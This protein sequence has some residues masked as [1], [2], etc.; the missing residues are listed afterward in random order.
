MESPDYPLSSLEKERISE[1]IKMVPKGYTSLLDVGARDGY[2]CRRLVNEFREIYLLDLEK[3]KIDEPSIRTVQ[4]DVTHLEFFGDSFDVVL[5]AEVLEHI[6]PELLDVACKEIARVSRH[7]VVIGV[8]Y[9][10]DIRVGRT[11]CGNC[12]WKNPPWGHV[13]WFDGEKLEKLFSPLTL[14]RRKFIGSKKAKTNFIS[15]FLMDLGGNPW[16]TYDQIETCIYCG[17][18]LIAPGKRNIFERA[19]SKASFFLNFLQSQFI[20]STP[21]WLYAVFKKQ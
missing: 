10:Q 17:K 11:T 8:P 18:K 7:Y 13:N 3:P 4:G 14:E 12:Q 20:S 19:C 21:R 2:I 5:C 6:K 1:I 9:K 16:G 15:A